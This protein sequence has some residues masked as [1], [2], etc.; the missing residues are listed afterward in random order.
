MEETI[1]LNYS[2]A[3]VRAAL[4]SVSYGQPAHKTLEF[5]RNFAAGVH[6]AAK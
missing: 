1:T 3:L 6:A 5:I 2:E 4:R